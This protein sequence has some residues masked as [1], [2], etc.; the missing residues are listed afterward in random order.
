MLKVLKKNV[1][2]I[3]ENTDIYKNFMNK[4]VIGKSLMN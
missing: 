1:G 3:L 4:A 2:L